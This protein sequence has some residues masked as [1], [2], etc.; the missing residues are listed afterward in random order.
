MKGVVFTEFLEMVEATFPEDMVDRMISRADLP[1]GGAYTSVGF[2]DHGE[3]VQLVAALSELTG[4]PVAELIRTFGRYL[5]GRFVK[6]F[7]GF[8]V[9]IS[10]SFEFLTGIETR[11][12]SEVRK[13][14]PDA[15]LPN[16]VVTQHGIERLVLDYKSRRPF[17]D[18]AHGLIEG[19]I[20]HYRETIALNREDRP[21]ADVQARFTLI[22]HSG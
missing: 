19:C 16:F 6:T 22:R 7:P 17:A 12:H 3:M 18:L 2:Y 1:S 14:Y 9:G 11:V 21:S 20:D 4:K 10:D 13:L 8:F 5:F 15:E